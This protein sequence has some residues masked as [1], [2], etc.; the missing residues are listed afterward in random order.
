MKRYALAVVLLACGTTPRDN[1]DAGADALAS[2]SGLVP[3]DAQ[4]SGCSD[5]HAVE[6]RAR[7][8]RAED[9]RHELL[10]QHG[11]HRDDRHHPVEH[12][13]ALPLLDVRPAGVAEL[14]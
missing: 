14:S 7:A 1:Y 9:L 3:S 2:D 4:Q 5:E 6:L 12:R 8:E 11:L 10:D 13:D